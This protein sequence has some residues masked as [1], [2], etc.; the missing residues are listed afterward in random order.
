MEK[1]HQCH[2]VQYDNWYQA[3]QNKMV[4]KEMKNLDNHNRH[5]N[6]KSFFGYG[7]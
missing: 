2:E 7:N 3:P 4:V 5:R 6:D 1:H